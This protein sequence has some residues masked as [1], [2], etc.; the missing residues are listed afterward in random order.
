MITIR[1]HYNDQ[2]DRAMKCGEVFMNKKLYDKWLAENADK[3]KN[4]T[5]V[6]LQ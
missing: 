1:F 5:T 4:L 2:G 6:G 3:I